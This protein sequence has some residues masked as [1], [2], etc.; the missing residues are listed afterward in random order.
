MIEVDILMD[1][2]LIEVDQVMPIPLGSLQQRSQVLDKAFP[3][4]GIS[5]TQQLSG[6]FPRQL[7]P[8]QGGADSLATEPPAKPRLHEPD[9]TA[10]RPAWGRI[11]PGYRWAGGLMLG[12]ADGGI[13]GRL[14]VWAKGGRPP[15]RR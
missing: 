15:V 7:E 4:R 11:S 5:A 9:Q 13:E 12:G 1:V 6:L 14:D 2:G 10:Q 8:L 3:L